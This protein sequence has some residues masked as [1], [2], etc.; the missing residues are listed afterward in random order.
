MLLQMGA[1][2]TERKYRLLLA[3]AYEHWRLRALVHER[4]YGVRTVFL[5]ART[6]DL[7]A[8]L[9]RG[10]VATPLGWCEE[11]VEPPPRAFYN[12]MARPGPVDARALR[13]LNGDLRAVVY[14]ESNR[15]NRGM[16]FDILA[17]APGTGVYV[18]PTVPYAPGLLHDLTARPGLFLLA[19]AR[20][21]LR[22]QG[23]LVE[24]TGTGELRVLKIREDATGTLR[25]DDVQGPLPPPLPAAPRWVS[26]LSGW[27]AGPGAP[28]EWRLYAHRDDAG[29]WCVAGAVAKHDALRPAG[30]PEVCW[31]FADALAHTFGPAAPDLAERLEA[32]ARAVAGAL[33]LFVPGISHCAVDFWIDAAGQPVLADL[34][35]L[36]RTDWLR[37]VA[38]T[39]ALQQLLDH[40]IRFALT[41]ARTGVGK[42]H[43]GF[44]RTGY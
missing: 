11:T 3:G 38:E 26:R 10:A 13:D 4:R 33:T 1:L 32:G 23:A 2:L 18:P 27:P 35:G 34:L 20:R 25:R 28:A 31:P 43:V 8:C 36:Y 5:P 19:P 39:R 37:R 17:A 7:D 42:L 30:R 12:L 14:N 44:G 40:P 16:V 9:V 41:L 29:A 24:A 22:E 6:V 21:P 15:W